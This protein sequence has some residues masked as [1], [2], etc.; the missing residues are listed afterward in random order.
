MVLAAV[1]LV[2]LNAGLGFV[3][4]SVQT[5]VT[6]VTHSKAWSQPSQGLP[7]STTTTG[8]A[9]Y[10]V[11]M[12]ATAAGVLLRARRTSRVARNDGLHGIKFP[13]A[14][15]KDAH[16]D[17]EYLNDVGHLAWTTWNNTIR[18]SFFK[19]QRILHSCCGRD[20][21]ICQMARH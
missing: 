19:T 11:A 18:V 6:G 7:E 15:Q 20:E 13:Y 10:G 14:L 21:A 8:T 12:V 1:S 2:I 17:L 5:K 3:A 16:A 4:P 9:F